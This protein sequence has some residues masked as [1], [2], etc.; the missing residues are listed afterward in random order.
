MVD[1]INN[2]GGFMSQVT[3]KVNHLDK[4]YCKMSAMQKQMACSCALQELWPE[5]FDHGA[6]KSWVHATP[7][8]V[9]FRLT[10]GR[11]ETREYPFESI[12]TVLKNKHYERAARRIPTF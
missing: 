8:K 9:I 4:Q 5:V 7:K 2:I 3:D 11:G 1:G 6:C 12:P 10:N